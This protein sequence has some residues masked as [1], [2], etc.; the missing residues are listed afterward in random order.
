MQ[1]QS[2][3]SLRVRSLI[4]PLLTLAALFSLVR[5][6]GMV[7]VLSKGLLT[8]VMA[9]ARRTEGTGGQLMN[10]DVEGCVCR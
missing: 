4:A 8:L 10:A 5:S 6:A 2:L 3:E 9:L 7:V 1:G